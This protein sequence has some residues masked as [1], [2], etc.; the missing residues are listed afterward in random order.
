MRRQ[1]FIHRSARTPNLQ[2]VSRIS[3]LASFSNT[4]GLVRFLAASNHR[5]GLELR[6]SDKVRGIAPGSSNSI[7]AAAT[8]TFMTMQFMTRPT[9]AAPAAS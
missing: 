1:E 5:L 7:P 4:S 8:M 9:L 3:Y 2:P 6:R